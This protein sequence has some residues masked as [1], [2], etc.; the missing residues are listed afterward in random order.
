[1]TEPKMLALPVS[2]FTSP[3]LPFPRDGDEGWEDED[4]GS[5][6]SEDEEGSWLEGRFQA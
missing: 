2:T 5:E 1:L 4:V 3:P 6:V